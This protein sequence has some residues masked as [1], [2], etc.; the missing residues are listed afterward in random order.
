MRTTCLLFVFALWILLFSSGCRGD[1]GKEAIIRP[2]QTIRGVETIEARLKEI[3]ITFS[4]AGTVRTA[5][6]ATLTSRIMG[7]VTRIGAKEG[8]RVEKGE[9]LIEIESQ[10]ITAKVRQ[11]QGALESAEAAFRNAEANY[12]R[13]SEL[14]ARGSATRLELDGATMQLDSARGGVKQ[15]EGTVREAQAMK[16]YA[17]IRAPAAGVVTRRMVEVG[18]QAAPGRPL[19]EFEDRSRL[20]FETFVPES[21]LP[22][23]TVGREVSVR[24]HALGDSL[25]PGRISE[26]EASAD[27]VS[28]SAKIK[29][30]LQGAKNALSGMYGKVI[31]PTGTRRAVLIPQGAVATKGQL[32]GV[33]L[34]DKAQTL[35][36]RLI[37]TGKTL[38]DEI[39]VLSGLEGGERIAA[40]RLDQLEEGM[41][42]R[43]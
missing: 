35:H 34:L 21:I 33:F 7:N 14:F 9:T 6:H 11:A 39:E 38:G 43:K 5:G 25:I 15:A 1:S 4:T 26:M 40:S 3:D 18:D 23:L 17:R 30:D 42:A 24:I 13:I 28:H 29:I 12:T 37:Q 27:P 19:L 36:L 20:Q 2:K 8:N 16:E 22:S 31:I 41:E 10:D 32:T